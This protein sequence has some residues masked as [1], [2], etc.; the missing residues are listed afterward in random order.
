MFHYYYYRCTGNILN[1][2]NHHLL[3]FSFQRHSFSSP[4]QLFLNPKTALNQPW[5]FYRP[6]HAWLTELTTLL[7]HHRLAIHVAMYQCQAF[8][9][10]KDSLVNPIVFSI[11]S[12]YRWRKSC[13]CVHL[14]NC[15][16]FE[17]QWC[18]T[19][20]LG[21]LHNKKIPQKCQSYYTTDNITTY[22]SSSRQKTIK[23]NLL[24][25]Y[26]PKMVR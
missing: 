20:M 5:T 9:R 22:S 21:R 12:M 3:L 26:R 11:H 23:T 8:H 14:L 17:S 7:R 19:M 16:W 13:R 6:H 4:P 25:T 10:P 15:C 1:F 2:K 18:P 24:I